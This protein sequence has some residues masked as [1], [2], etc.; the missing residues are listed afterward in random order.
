MNFEFCFSIN[1]IVILSKIM[2]T[3]K[4][5]QML[6]SDYII[7]KIKVVL[8]KHH[9]PVK[10]INAMST[11]H[12]TRQFLV[13]LHWK[14]F[15]KCLVISL[16][17]VIS[18]TFAICATN[19]ATYCSDKIVGRFDDLDNTA[20]CTTFVYCF[21]NNTVMAGVKLKCAGTT[22]FNTTNGICSSSSTCTKGT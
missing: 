22:L 5:H 9:K 20:N 3:P 14:M 7:F 2:S 13:D 6:L 8:R 17:L 19:L 16:I 12:H 18:I 1:K 15:L 11:V 21:Y 10:H 4:A